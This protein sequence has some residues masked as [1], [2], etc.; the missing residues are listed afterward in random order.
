[1]SYWMPTTPFTA[2]DAVNRASQAMG[3]SAHDA[4]IGHRVTV[5]QSI[6][7]KNAGTWSAQYIWAGPRYVVR[8]VS[9]SEAIREAIREATKGRSRGGSVVVQMSE[10]SDI[11]IAAGLAP[12]QGPRTEFD[13][14]A[15]TMP[16]QCG[17]TW[18]G[19]T[20]IGYAHMAVQM[21]R[22]RGIPTYLFLEA[23]SKEDWDARVMAF[24]SRRGVY[25]GP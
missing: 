4:D 17:G 12:Y 14:I 8:R 15:A 5:F 23:S 2:I 1:M 7:D 16:W 3:I 9:L 13:H 6:P 21:E 11:C 19:S 10:N 24:V 18:L 20:S 25:V 22:S